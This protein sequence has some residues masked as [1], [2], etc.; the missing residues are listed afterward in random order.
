LEVEA[1][2][3]PRGARPPKHLHPH[4]DE[5]FTVLRG[6]IRVGL[7]DG[8]HDFTAGESFDIVRGVVHHMWNPGEQAATV[9]WLSM[10][11]MRVESFFRAMDRLQ[12]AGRPRL[13]DQ[14]RVLNGYQDV[15]RPASAIARTLVRVV[16]ASR[17]AR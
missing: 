5:A 10:P 11:A 17:T 3:A 4:H 14:A 8:E 1:T 9:R 13:I 16:G 12:R 7:A 2:Y 15:I 6:T